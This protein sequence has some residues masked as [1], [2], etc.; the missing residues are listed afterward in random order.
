[1]KIPKTL[2]IYT[3]SVEMH[4]K[5]SEAARTLSV[6]KLAGVE[7]VW[8]SSSRNSRGVQANLTEIVRVK[9]EWNGEGRP[10]VGTVC[11]IR[12]KNG[13]WSE[14]VIRYISADVCVWEWCS[15]APT[16]EFFHA[17]KGMQFRPI[18]T[19][20]QIKA[21]SDA[22]ATSVLTEE[23]EHLVLVSERLGPSE[24]AEKLIRLNYR[25]QTDQ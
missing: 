8:V 24:L 6:E 21:E 15:N 10:P 9:S 7:F 11:E 1:M 18:R 20:E 17:T 25:K 12:C 3:D 2:T 13:N 22:I 4:E 16:I 14:G 5:F 23:L 19:P